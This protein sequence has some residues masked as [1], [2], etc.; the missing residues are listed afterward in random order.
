MKLPRT[1]KPL[2]ELFVDHRDRLDKVFSQRLGPTVDGRYLH[3]DKLRHLAVPAGMQSPEEWW[4][5]LKL[6]RTGLYRELPLRDTGGRPFV[7][8]L[9]DGVHE[10]LHRIDSQSHGWIGAAAHGVAN[11][12]T[13][14]QFIVNSLIEEAIASSQLEGA[15]T[16]RAVAAEMIRAGRRPRDRSEQMILNN[17]LAMDAIRR[18][19]DKSLT[20]DAVM[21]LHTMITTDT[22]DDPDDA[23]RVQRPADQRVLVWDTRDQTVLHSPPPAEDLAGRMREMVRF[24]N[25]GPVDGSFLHPV[26]HAIV[27][28]FWLAHDHPFA[29]GNGRTARAL[30]YWAMLH[31]KY[32]MFEFAS[33]SNVL[34]KAPGQYA[35][36]FLHTETDDNDL[37][38]FIEHQLGVILRAI[39]DVESY[40]TRKTEQVRQ[41]E[42]TLKRSTNLNHRQLALLAH[43][44]RHPNAEYTIRSHMT[45][46]TVAYATARADLFRLADLGLLE[47]R[48]VGRRS[49]LFWPPP[50][51]ADRIRS[52]PSE[53]TAS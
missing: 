34:T 18:L 14:N 52:A 26:L 15:S 16:T 39:A 48:R 19:R 20:D 17:Y 10:A 28:H 44:I 30:F 9:S 46:H 37:T 50:D 41:V 53:K 51:L 32:W 8:L 33:I 43:A 45:S 27:L 25:R 49:Y 29:D 1:P 6:A 23:G 4:L 7:Y 13:R 40:I 5:A 24:A 47:R 36:S 2:A 21:D 12:D 3:W 22:L 31:H 38:Y 11:T 42:E 35:R